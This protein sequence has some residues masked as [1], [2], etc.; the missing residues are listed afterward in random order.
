MAVVGLT[1]WGPREMEIDE[2]SQASPGEV[3]PGIGNTYDPV[4]PLFG[5]WTTRPTACAILAEEIIGLGMDRMWP[6]TVSEFAAVHSSC[7]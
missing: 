7:I 4:N 2:L 5:R 3:G 6:G 1:C